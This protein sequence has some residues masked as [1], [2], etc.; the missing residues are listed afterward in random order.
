MQTSMSTAQPGRFQAD[1]GESGNLAH[2]YERAQDI[3][4]LLLHRPTL[5]EVA[6][7]LVL[8]GLPALSPWQVGIYEVQ[9]NSKLKLLGAFG[10]DEGKGDLDGRSC[11][12]TPLVREVFRWRQP[13]TNLPVPEGE[14]S[15]AQQQDEIRT[16]PG[17]V[18]G[19]Q[20]IW[21]LVTPSRLGGLLQLRFESPVI[22]PEAEQEISAI[23]PV[24][25]LLL[26]LI[27]MMEEVSHN[28]QPRQ[29][30][31]W[32]ASN[33]DSGQGHDAG[34]H[35]ESMDWRRGGGRPRP[36]EL[37]PRQLRVLEYVA[38]GMTN[39][40]IARALKFSEST[41]R[42]ETMAIYRFLQVPGRVEAVEVALERGILS[43]PDPAPAE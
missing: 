43:S 39:G 10:L 13:Q 37:S 18:D 8:S 11:L 36:R 5:D 27:T 3:I 20:L 34:R 7:Y 30:G 17:S 23:A 24:M 38:Q 31:L 25:S 19:P 41:V 29:L 21:P 2:A 6:Q 42:Q 26:E 4:N 33:A 40:Q 15:E 28:G 22:T 14:V 35:D 16:A 12:E 32:P 1:A 9:P